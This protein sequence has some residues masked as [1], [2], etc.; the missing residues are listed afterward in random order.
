MVIGGASGIGEA[1]V[2][3]RVQKGDKVIFTDINEKMGQRLESEL[4]QTNTFATFMKHDVTSWQETQNIKIN[5]MDQFNK[6]DTLIYS[7]GVTSQKNIREITFEEWSF[8]FNVN[9]T[10]LFYSL[11]TFIPEM[12]KRSGGNIVIV[13]SGS[14]IT[15]S[16]GGAHY[17]ASK[18]GAFGMM[19]A[20]ADEFSERGIR[21]NLVAPR[22]IETEMLYKLYPTEKQLEDLKNKIPI[23]KIGTLEDT[24]NIINFLESSSANYIQ[25]QTLI[26]D[27]GRTYLT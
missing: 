8:T 6:I 4:N 22:V 3:N 7:A 21:I 5:V 11:K 19:R 18:G 9:L 25:A 10:G 13:G 23:K 20:I 12:V 14:A 17:S 26:A 1:V 2:R 27:G 15:G 16:G 24:T